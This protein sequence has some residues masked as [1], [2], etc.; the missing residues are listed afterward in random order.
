MKMYYRFITAIFTRI[1]FASYFLLQKTQNHTGLAPKAS[2]MGSAFAEFAIKGADK[3]L[4]LISDWLKFGNQ[5]NSAA[6]RFKVTTIIANISF[7][8]ITMISDTRSISC[9]TRR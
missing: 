9:S 6:I 5:V 1:F 3:W 2:F 4:V 7:Q 8:E